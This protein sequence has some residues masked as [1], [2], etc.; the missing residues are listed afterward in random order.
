[1]EYENIMATERAINRIEIP[2]DRGFNIMNMFIAIDRIIRINIVVIYNYGSCTY[3]V[4]IKSLCALYTN[5]YVLI[6]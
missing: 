4:N 2:I 5:L 1:M 6:M 3:S